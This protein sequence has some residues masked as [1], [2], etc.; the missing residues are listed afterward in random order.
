MYDIKYIQNVNSLNTLNLV[1]NNLDVYI[2]K[3]GENI[4]LTFASTEKN[5]IM[6]KNYMELWNETKEQINSINSK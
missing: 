5:K 2:E 6:L 3:G 4:Y 1:F